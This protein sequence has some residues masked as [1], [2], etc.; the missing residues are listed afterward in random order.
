MPPRRFT[1]EEARSLLARL[2]PLLW[3]MREK[4]QEHDAL[5][6]QLDEA[7]RTVRSNG[8]GMETQISSTQRAIQEAATRVNEIAERI[9]QLGCELKDVDQGLVDFRHL[10]ED[11]REVYLCWKL[12]EVDI[13]WW[14]ELTTGFGSRQRLSTGTDD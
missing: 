12:G 13:E 4:K 7:Q 8:H 11:G 5:R 1:L 9:N 10:R 2:A 14:H 3:E 6:A